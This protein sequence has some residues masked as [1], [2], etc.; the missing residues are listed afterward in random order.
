MKKLISVLIWLLFILTLLFPV[1]KTVLG[2][3]GCD[4]KLISFSGF[5]FALATL[6]VCT[7]IL[8]VFFDDKTGDEYIGILSSVTA[9]L[10]LIN[11]VFYIFVCHNFTVCICIWIYAGCSF[12]L[13]LNRGGPLKL[14]NV[15]LVLAALMAVPI[16]LF[17]FF[18]L[19]FGNLGQ[20]TVVQTV[21]S[22]RVSIMPRLLTATKEHWAVILLCRSARKR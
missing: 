8:D 19:T 5:A 9:P 20:N 13:A 7:V 6:S 18:M 2:Y 17:C 4:F 21:E 16:S 12:L 3:F 10:S 1:G 14:R 22:P 15:A 11:A